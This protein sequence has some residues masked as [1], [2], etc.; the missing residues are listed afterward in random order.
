MK[1]LTALEFLLE[2]PELGVIG[3]IIVLMMVVAV[4]YVCNAG[5]NFLADL[6]NKDARS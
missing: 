1:T 2:V 3:L 5:V 4:F 6:L